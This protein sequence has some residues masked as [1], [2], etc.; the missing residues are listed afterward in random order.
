[1]PQQHKNHER[2]LVP[3]LM[4][5]LELLQ[6]FDHETPALRLSELAQKVGMSRSSAFRIAYT[7]ET[8]GFLER[9][10]NGTSYRLA[11]KVLN[12]GFAYLDSQEIVDIA[13]PALEELRNAINLTTHLAILEG[14]EIVH[15]VRVAGNTPM[16]SNVAIG[17]RRPAYA[18]PLGRA[19]LMDKSPAELRTIFGAGKLKKYTDFTP[20]DVA[21]L[22]KLVAA[23]AAQ[24]YV[25]S[26]GS[27]VPGGGSVAAPVRDRKGEI[28]AAINASGPVELFEPAAETKFV[29][30]VLFA[31]GKI[32]SR[33]GYDG[34]RKGRVSSET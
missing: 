15:L 9:E 27:F 2:Y 28:V 17:T 20:G 4:R 14:R 34:M 21:E 12:L 3:G 7:L 31:A 26:H 13:R 8:M 19:L 23:D 10:T 24:G 33:L 29:E 5:G 22:A 16:T 25:I 6:S 18:A 11:S 32:S 30:K 1:M